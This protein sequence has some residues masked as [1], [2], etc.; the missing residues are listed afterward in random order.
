MTGQQGRIRQ[1]SP[2]APTTF[3]IP[4]ANFAAFLNTT[5]PAIMTGSVMDIA[6]ANAVIGQMNCSSQNISDLSGIEYFTSI[7]HLFC[8]INNLTPL[9]ISTLN[10][11][12]LRAHQNSLTSITGLAN[13]TIMGHLW[14]GSNERTNRH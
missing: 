3:T 6:G 11:N 2:A 8:E 9:D 7:T 13:Q 1:I 10:L 14:V 5:Y 12:L 4:D